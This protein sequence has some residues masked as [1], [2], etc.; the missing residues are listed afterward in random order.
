MLLEQRTV[1]KQ[2]PS[3]LERLRS[4]IQGSVKAM[5]ASGR[6]RAPE[7]SPA[8]ARRLTDVGYP[9]AFYSIK[10]GLV[11]AA[12]L[13]Q[14]CEEELYRSGRYEAPFS[15][16][17]VS[18]P[19]SEAEVVAWA[20]AGLRKMDVFGYVGAGDYAAFLPDTDWQMARRLAVRVHAV[21]PAVDTGTS[22]CPNDGRAF[23]E[24]LAAAR[25][26]FSNGAD[27]R[28]LTQRWSQPPQ[29]PEKRYAA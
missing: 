6:S 3:Q 29:A 20:R 22:S 26:R 19:E 2:L 5:Q 21:V 10:A 4:R 9:R 24:L 11:S 18:A 14:R 25:G 28:P 27:R 23:H 17:V 15:L 8:T 16:L 13:S 1:P 12:Y 7:T